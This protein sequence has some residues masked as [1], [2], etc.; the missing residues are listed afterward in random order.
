MALINE[1][2]SIKPVNRFFT[3][4]LPS[5]APLSTITLNEKMSTLNFHSDPYFCF[6]QGKFSASRTKHRLVLLL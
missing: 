2:V 6:E 4:S 5:F 1:L 3:L